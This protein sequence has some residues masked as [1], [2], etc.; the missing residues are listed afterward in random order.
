MHLQAGFG[1]QSVSSRCKER[2][3]KCTFEPVSGCIS[4]VQGAKILRKNA[5]SSRLRGA[6]C[7]AE[8]LFSYQ[9]FALTKGEDVEH[10][11]TYRLG[12]AAGSPALDGFKRAW[13]TAVPQNTHTARYIVPL[14]P[15]PLQ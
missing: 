3:T 14:L 12:I 9:Y 13:E 6:V 11:K 2:R 8:V 10:R 1:V 15:I 5:P 4:K 7:S